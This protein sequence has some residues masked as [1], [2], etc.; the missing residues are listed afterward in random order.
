[1]K[2]ANWRQEADFHKQMTLLVKKKTKARSVMFVK[3]PQE[4]YLEVVVPPGK[5]FRFLVETPLD[6]LR[7]SD[8]GEVIKSVLENLAMSQIENI[9]L[10]TNGKQ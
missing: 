3:N 9:N 1:M 5:K 6:K 10:Q 2:K 7:A 4:T 8:Y